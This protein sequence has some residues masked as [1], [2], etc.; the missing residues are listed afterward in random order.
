MTHGQ[1]DARPTVTFP[2]FAG[3]KFILLVR[4][5]PITFLV[6]N[7]ARANV[8]DRLHEFVA[9]RKSAKVKKYDNATPDMLDAS[10]TRRAVRITE[11]IFSQKL[12]Q[13]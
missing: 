2:A 8:S 6:L 9:I 7:P 10:S 13:R 12:K 4:T 5:T 3:T 1:C 11:L